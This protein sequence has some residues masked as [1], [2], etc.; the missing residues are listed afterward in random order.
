MPTPTRRALRRAGHSPWL[1]IAVY[2]GY[3]GIDGIFDRPAVEPFLPAWLTVAWTIALIAGAALVIVGT[4]SARPRAESAGHGLHLAGIVIYAACY[5]TSLNVG[6]VVAV[7]A[8]GSVVGIRMHVL[9]GARA[10]RQE[11]GHLLRPPGDN[12]GGR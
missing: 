6:A 2:L 9:S 8:L 10:A 7:L 1:P 5:A 4:L 11:A 12:E 3:V